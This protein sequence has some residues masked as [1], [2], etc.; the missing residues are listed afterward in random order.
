MPCGGYWLHMFGLNMLIVVSKF[1]CPCSLQK[2]PCDLSQWK[3]S[4]LALSYILLSL[5]I[6]GVE[7]ALIPSL[8][9]SL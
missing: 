9:Q 3:D 2:L 5:C 4:L 6:M 7:R 8:S 1:S